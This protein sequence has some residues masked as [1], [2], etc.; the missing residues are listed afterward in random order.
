M[1]PWRAYQAP[2]PT[3]H[4]NPI[5]RAYPIEMIGQAIATREAAVADKR[6]DVDLVIP[7]EPDMELTASKTAEAV[8][9]F[10]GLDKDKIDEIKLALIEAC[11]NAIE[12]SKS[13]DRRVSINFEIGE[14]ELTLYISDRGKGF[15]LSKVHRELAS[16]KQRQDRRGWGLKIMEELMDRVE[17]D[18]DDR[19][20]IIT[21]VKHR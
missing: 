5:F 13:A 8:G 14:K 3:H 19:G 17:V 16:G 18:S 9:E 15:D 1:P 20:T 10:M 12:H 21:M 6:T 4:E 7:M 2:Q 11:I